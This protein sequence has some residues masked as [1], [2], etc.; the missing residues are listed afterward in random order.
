MDTFGK[1][2]R[3]AVIDKISSDLSYV[4]GKLYRIDK[5]G[6]KQ[7]IK[8]HPFL[9]FW[10]RPNPLYEFT[11][12]ALWKLQNNYLLLKG[13]GYFV[14]E[15]YE[16]GYPAELWPVP[17]HWVQMTPYQGFPFYRVRMADG[18]VIDISVDDM[19]VMRDLDPLE[20]YK[21]GLGQAEA[22]ADEIE[23]DE[24]A[25]KFQKKFFYNDATPGVI[26][27]LPGAGD[28]QVNRFLARWKERF[29]GAEKS[30]SVGAFGGPKDVPI[31]VT[32]LS[33]NMKDLDMVNGR[34]FT[35]DAVMEHFG[36][37]REIMGITQNSNRATA[38]AARYIYATN[39]LTPRLMNRQDAINLQL[40]PIYGRDLLWEFDDII[41]KDKEFEK[42]VAFDGWNNG[43]LTKNEA[44]EKLDLEPAKKGDVFKMNFAD[45]YIGDDEDP[46][47]LSSSAANLQYSD[48]AEPIEAD[49]NDIEVVPDGAQ[50]SVDLDEGKVLKRAAE[51]KAQRAR[52]AGRGLDAARRIQ[53]RKFEQATEKYLRDQAQQIQGALLGNKKADGTV[54]DAL[55]MTQDEFLQLSDQQQAELTMQF[56]NG[57][58]D[59]KKEESI[60]ESILTPLWAETYDKGV[61]NVIASYRLQ[62]IQQPALTSTAR[63]RGGQRVTRVTQT[64]KDN[65][66][67]IVTEG[68]VRGKG[69]Q[70]LT[71]EI[72]DEMNTSATRARVIAA[73]ECN[74][75]LL[76]GNYDMAKRGGFSFKTWHVTNPGKARDTHRELNGKTVPFSEPF[77]TSKGN[78]LMM[79]C[80]PECS[81][82]EE[83]VNCHCFLTFS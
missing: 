7:E 21:R 1:N 26:V 38:E 40:L 31:S 48:T 4:P 61:E 36:M 3:M 8:A 11:A 69:K 68:L 23:I 64:T 66:G 41:P 51:I 77:V 30:H 44:R 37:P 70:E 14:I 9:D 5:D 50:S 80:D 13:E 79:P 82:A 16:N 35:R 53:T 46:V 63:L 71:E 29:Q 56:V 81:V 45:L 2:P 43:L 10:A 27:N 73:Q 33:D 83:T 47:E 24:Y 52:A 49:R 17:P 6:E 62:A 32:K 19:F 28:D 34:A 39:V 15:R 12:S 74:T 58:L 55:N 22:V 75:S 57:L 20:P 59:W 54:W 78:K 72:M 65:I 25:A 18:A 76:A 60:L 42:G 67:R